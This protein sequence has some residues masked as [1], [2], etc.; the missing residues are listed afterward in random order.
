[1]KRRTA[2][3]IATVTALCCALSQQPSDAAAGRRLD[4]KVRKEVAFQ[5]F[6]SGPRA[7]DADTVVEGKAFDPYTCY[8]PRCY[9]VTFA[10]VPARGVQGDLAIRVDWTWFFGPEQ[11]HDVYLVDAAR[12]VVASCVNPGGVSRILRVPR[13]RLKPGMS[14]LVVVDERRATV[15]ESVDGAVQF[16]A[17]SAPVAAAPAE[18]G[19]GADL[20]CAIPGL[21]HL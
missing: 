8:K 19:H 2:L 21:G 4:G 6:P 20:S 17:T 16:P 11:A 13:A 3:G 9:R 15:G 10:F 5:D 1:M 18:V 14:Y 12:R 7:H